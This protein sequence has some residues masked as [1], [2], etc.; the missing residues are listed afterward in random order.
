MIDENTGFDY[1]VMPMETNN[2]QLIKLLEKFAERLDSISKQLDTL[3]NR[4]YFYTYSAPPPSYPSGIPLPPNVIPGSPAAPFVD[5]WH[6]GDPPNG[7]TI[8]C[9]HEIPGTPFGDEITICK[10]PDGGV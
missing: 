1:Q 4:P 6:I 3:V 5:P 8:T 2:D 7:P 10:H 9:R